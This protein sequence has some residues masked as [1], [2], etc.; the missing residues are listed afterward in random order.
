[1]IQFT[2]IVINTLSGTLV[3]INTHRWYT[4][5]KIYTHASTYT[6]THTYTHTHTHTHTHTCSCSSLLGMGHVTFHKGG[7]KNSHHTTSAHLV[8]WQWSWHSHTVTKGLSVTP[9]AVCPGIVVK[10]TQAA[11]VLHADLN[12]PLRGLQNLCRGTRL[13]CAKWGS[14]LGL[15][16]RIQPCDH[17][18]R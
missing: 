2:W 12:Y 16:H 8:Y 5:I 11:F 10:P 13:V 9:A 7:T 6:K 15:A 14:I 18:Q 1:M 3:H 17:C 4:N